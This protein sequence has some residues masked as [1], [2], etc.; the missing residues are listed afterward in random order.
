MSLVSTAQSN[1][2]VPKINN[3]LK[4]AINEIEHPP[5]R[6][7]GINPYIGI[8]SRAQTDATEALNL[9]QTTDIYPVRNHDGALKN[10]TAGVEKLQSVLDIKGINPPQA[11]EMMSAAADNFDVAL[12]E[13]N[14]H[15]L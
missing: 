5:A 8:A 10:A 11:F 3:L 13:L 6:N 9:L 2:V 15:S 4:S 1:P 7:P 14:R 12:K